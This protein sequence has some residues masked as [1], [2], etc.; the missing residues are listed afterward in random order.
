MGARPARF[1]EA[2]EEASTSPGGMR[3]GQHK[4]WRPAQVLEACEEPSTSLGGMLGGQNK[5]GRH[6]KRPA[7]VLE[8][9]EGQP[10]A[11]DHIPD[12]GA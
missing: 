9:C 10:R 6:A 12:T 4:S 5:S 11:A 1:L 8:A 2:C 3:G 7:Q